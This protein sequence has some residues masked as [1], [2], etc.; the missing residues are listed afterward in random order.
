MGPSEVTTAAPGSRSVR[1]Y[2]IRRFY[3]NHPDP[4]DIE[5]PMPSIT[6]DDIRSMGWRVAIHNDYWVNGKWY[7]FWLFTKGQMCAKGAGRADS[8]ALEE[9]HKQVLVAER[10]AALT[11]TP[12]ATQLCWEVQKYFIEPA[13]RCLKPASHGGA[14]STPGGVLAVTA[15]ARCLMHL[16]RY[17]DGSTTMYVEHCMQAAGHDGACV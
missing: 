1:S 3:T 7:T 6:A 13:H 5:E 10:G 8:E 14:C 2:T 9:V 4:I 11:E 16:L 17:R 15:G 12:K